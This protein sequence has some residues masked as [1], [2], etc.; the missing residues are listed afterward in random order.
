M[1]DNY[2]EKKMEEHR[3]GKTAG[4]P[5][6]ITPA[7]IK[8][9][10]ALIEYPVKNVF[11]ACSSCFGQA[12][13]T[14]IRTF[15]CAGCHVSM[16]SA[17]TE[18]RTSAQKWGAQLHPFDAGD[19]TKLKAAMKFAKERHTGIEDVF[20]DLRS[21]PDR[22]TIINAHGTRTFRRLPSTDAGAFASAFANLAL[23]ATA[24]YSHL[25]VRDEIEI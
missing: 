22:A 20:V 3:Q 10:K 11:I 14:V 17:A 23:L 18:A 6:R 2:L 7:G 4:A 16:A 24:P 5:R 15:C 13:E 1:A 9:G 21:F 25:I 8:T 19:E 12:D